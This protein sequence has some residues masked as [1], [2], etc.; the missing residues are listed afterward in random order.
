MSNEFSSKLL[1]NAVNQFAK[2]PGIGKKTA[3]RLVLNLFNRGEEEV[4]KFAQSILDLKQ[5]AQKCKICNN[6]SDGEICDI[7]ADQSRDHS[8]ICVVENIKDIIAIEK[9]MQFNGVYHVL[10][11]L[12][13][14]L[15]GISVEDLNFNSLDERL[16]TR[17]VSEVILALSTTIEGDTTAFY[18][19]KRLLQYNVEITTIAR[20]IGFGDELEY[21]DEMTL[22]KAIA[23]RVKMKL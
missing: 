4:E 20:G 7:C 16:K 15:E 6:I 12:L 5:K 8:V 19:H 17:Q 13:S 10:G 11:G 3:L 2:L 14:P 18:L 1:E 21:T 23:N 9:T 22:G